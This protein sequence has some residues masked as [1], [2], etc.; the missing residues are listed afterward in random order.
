M[1]SLFMYV[2]LLLMPKV[3]LLY[4][5]NYI[6]CGGHMVMDGSPDYVW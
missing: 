6:F 2:A 1:F 4:D 3:E 5:L